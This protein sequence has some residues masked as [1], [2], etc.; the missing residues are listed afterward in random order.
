MDPKQRFGKMI[1]QLSVNYRRD[2]S[3]ADIAN[4]KLMFKQWGIDAL[5]QGVQKHMFDPDEG[6]FFPNIA[7]IAKHIE[8]TSKQKQ[9]DIE[10]KASMA[11]QTILGEISRIG[12]YETLEIDDKQAIAAVKAIGGW[13]HVCSLT[14]DKLVWAGKEFVSAYEQYER[15]DIAELPEKLPGRIELSEHKSEQKDGFKSLMKGLEDYKKRYEERKNG[16]I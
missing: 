12:S 13:K 11:W 7:N 16:N 5:E 10:G 14:T 2:L 6:K 15:S 9:K 3:E 4:F 8:G 1:A